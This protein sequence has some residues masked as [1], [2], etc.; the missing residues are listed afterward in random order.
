MAIDPAEHAP[1]ADPPFKPATQHPDRQLPSSAPSGTAT[2]AP[3]PSRSFF[4]RPILSTTPSG[5]KA[6]S[7]TSSAT[8]SLRAQPAKRRS[9]ERS[10]TRK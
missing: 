9:Q 3:A 4:G 8:N 1:V 2:V 6:R 10:R 7:A 5:S